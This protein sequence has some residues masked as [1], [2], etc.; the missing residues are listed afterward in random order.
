MRAP[1]PHKDR[2]F[3]SKTTAFFIVILLLALLGLNYWMA[4]S[5]QYG[6]AADTTGGSPFALFGEDHMAGLVHGRQLADYGRISA[7]EWPGYMWHGTVKEILLFWPVLLFGFHEIIPVIM[8]A[9]MGACIPLLAFLLTYR[10]FGTRAALIA[11]VLCGAFDIFV[12]RN[13]FMF[14]FPFDA[15]T[16]LSL[17]LAFL[18]LTW[19]H[20]ARATGRQPGALFCAVTG[21]LAGLLLYAH[22]VALPVWLASAIF[23]V[24]SLGRRLLSWRLAVAAFGALMGSARLWLYWIHH[25]PVAAFASLDTTRSRRFTWSKYLWGHGGFFSYTFSPSGN[26]WAEWIMGAIFVLAAVYTAWRLAHFLLVN[27]RTTVN[28]WWKHGLP[29][30]LFAYGVILFPCFMVFMHRMS[31]VARFGGPVHNYSVELWF[32]LLMAAAAWLDRLW[33]RNRYVG[34]ALTGA[35]AIFMYQNLLVHFPRPTKRMLQWCAACRDD[36]ATLIRQNMQPLLYVQE[37]N[38][39]LYPYF[40]PSRLT[41]ADGWWNLGLTDPVDAVESCARPT[42]LGELDDNVLGKNTWRATRLKTAIVY[43]K[44]RMPPPGRWIPPD[45]WAW[46]ANGSPFVKGGV[47]C[48]A[49]LA[50]ALTLSQTPG[51]SNLTWEVRFD[52]PRDVCRLVMTAVCAG[53]SWWPSTYFRFKTHFMLSARSSEIMPCPLRIEGLRTK[54]GIWQVLA[55]HA[56]DS[57]FFWDGGRLFFDSN[58]RYRMDIRFPATSITTLRLTH[59]CNKDPRPRKVAELALFESGDTPAPAIGTDSRLWDRIRILA[60]RRV[61]A[62]R[63]VSAQVHAR[64]PAVAVWRPSVLRQPVFLDDCFSD[65]PWYTALEPLEPDNALIVSDTAWAP[66]IAHT[67]TTEDIVFTQEPFGAWT[68]FRL[69]AEQSGNVRR[70]GLVWNGQCLLSFPRKDAARLWL[71]Q[72]RQ[73]WQTGDKARAVAAAERALAFHPRCYEA[74]RLLREWRGDAS[75]SP[76]TRDWLQMPPPVQP[77]AEGI[78]F[79]N[80][81]ILAAVDVTPRQARAGETVTLRSCWHI[82]PH[83][84]GAADRP[85]LFCHMRQDDYTLNADHTLLADYSMFDLLD[86]L[87]DE[88]MGDEYVL[89]VPT[90][91]PPGRYQIEC[92]LIQQG[93]RVPPACAIP[94]VR[95]DCRDAVW[96]DACSVSR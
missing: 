13:V 29:L 38:G 37:M 32:W 24:L 95:V 56:D 30:P 83:W 40:A 64:N 22:P 93:R 78:R 16:V 44:F 47:M 2:F 36:A 49:N 76:E 10:M 26:P 5:R 46:S 35:L 41:A 70:S 8:A 89:H 82:P 63:Y 80:G 85:L 59:S 15:Q 4:N 77:L 7:F 14:A 94:G 84:P 65:W 3:I 79:R 21:A 11:M 6:P 17:G 53:R 42:V 48:D 18:V 87:P 73:A 28:E 25:V 81:A 91:A 66:F 51:V 74:G 39:C 60:P 92:G 86:N 50:T 9:L 62:D 23:L 67:L 75:G 57:N 34:L 43:D 20:T 96:L 71:E 69:M 1:A 52:Q 33:R 31:G 54:D 68:L 27:W 90:N 61:Y 12:A 45:A 72:A 88:N 19:A 58:E 55:D